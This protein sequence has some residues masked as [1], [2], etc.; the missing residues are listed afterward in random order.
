MVPH[1]AIFAFLARPP[2]RHFTIFAKL[3]RLPGFSNYH[4]PTYIP[5]VL[6]VYRVTL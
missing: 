4:L 2:V 1:F 3:E 5:A 6:E